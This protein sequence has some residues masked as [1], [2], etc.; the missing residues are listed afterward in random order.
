M[1]Y[2]YDFVEKD[3][4]VND[5]YR[6]LLNRIW[7]DDTY[8]SSADFSYI[9]TPKSELMV[10]M[11]NFDDEK[12]FYDGFVGQYSA[13]FRVSS[14]RDI[15]CKLDPNSNTIDKP[16]LYRLV[17]TV[18]YSKHC[19]SAVTKKGSLLRRRFGS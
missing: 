11:E 14:V 6:E 13:E 8:A 1:G 12:P 7:D 4:S 18:H 10:L 9:S 5:F 17:F 15:C 3:D 19:P 16:P 2:L